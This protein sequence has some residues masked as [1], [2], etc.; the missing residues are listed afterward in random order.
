MASHP[1]TLLLLTLTLSALA[2]Q[3]ISNSDST[4]ESQGINTEG[5]SFTFSEL[6]QGGALKCYKCGQP[7]DFICKSESGIWNVCNQHFSEHMVEKDLGEVHK[8][9]PAVFQSCLAGDEGNFEQCWQKSV[10]IDKEIKDMEEILSKLETFE[11]KLANFTKTAYNSLTNKRATLS[12]QALH[13]ERGIKN[14]MKK[15]RSEHTSAARSISHIIKSRPSV[16][17]DLHKQKL[18][19]A[20]EGY[21]N[22]ESDGGEGDTDKPD[23]DG[24]D[25]DKDKPDDDGQDKDKDKDD[26]NGKGKDKDKD[27]EDGKG[28]DDGDKKELVSLK[29]GSK[30][31][32]KINLK[33]E[34]KTEVRSELEFPAGSAHCTLPDGNIIL[35]GGLASDSSSKTVYKVDPQSGASKKLPSMKD[36]RMYP[37]IYCHG[38]HVYVFGGLKA[39]GQRLKTSERYNIITETWTE[40]DSLP[41]S[42]N[43]AG[44]TKIDSKLYI[45]GIGSAN[46]MTFNLNTDK[47]DEIVQN[48]QK[49]S[50]AFTPVILASNDGYLLL[51]AD[52][53]VRVWSKDLKTQVKE[54]RVDVDMMTWSHTELAKYGGSFYI[55]VGGGF[56]KMNMDSLAVEEV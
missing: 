7:A 10:D 32:M 50:N 15:V 44:V 36:K 49:L 37:G 24:K 25:K 30:K 42:L 6:T 12:F 53:K 56:Y 13:T 20:I 48:G 22:V 39:Y 9:M 40:I 41:S 2:H 11:D 3:P 17:M 47:F 19:E 8:P 45:A 16:Q 33:N 51:V 26:E 4:D 55:A 31:I 54:R 52:Y 5:H 21:A 23:D 35:V 29:G 28:K 18:T 1:L 34:N 38:N 14:Y 43:K 27:D 46:V